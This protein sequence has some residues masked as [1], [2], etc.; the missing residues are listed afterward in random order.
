M[1]KKSSYKAIIKY[2]V[3]AVIM[4]ILFSAFIYRNTLR[5]QLSELM[6]KCILCNF[7][8]RHHCKY[9]MMGHRQCFLCDKVPVD[10]DK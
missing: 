8:N 7:E 9:C 2:A 3:Y 5:S 4:I 1:Q 10:S 6:Q